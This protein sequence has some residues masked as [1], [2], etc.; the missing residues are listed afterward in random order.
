MSDKKSP[1]GSYAVIENIRFKFADEPELWWE[2]K[3]PTTGDELS[4]TRFLTTGRATYN[5]DGGIETEG[6][7]SWLDIL[8]FEIAL[9]FGG[10][11]IPA[12]QDKPLKDGGAPYLIIDEGVDVIQGK[13]SAMPLEMITEIADKIAE[14]VPGWG[15]K[16]P[17]GR[18]EDPKKKE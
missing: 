13:L 16:N 3:P 15:P 4:L 9:L 6:G 14:T 8:I 10:T 17:L 18:T 5:A 7:P 11:N 2:I 12:D 1:F